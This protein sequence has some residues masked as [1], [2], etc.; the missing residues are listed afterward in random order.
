MCVSLLNFTLKKKNKRYFS[1][2][3]LIVISQ[4]PIKYVFLT[5]LHL[6]QLK[7]GRTEALFYRHSDSNGFE[8]MTKCYCCCYQIKG[9]GILEILK[10]RKFL[11]MN[12]W[13][14]R[15]KNKILGIENIK[16]HKNI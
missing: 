16:I 5:L 15:G 11:E 2:H 10:G 3:R 13:K 7:R 1:A 8:D 12:Y 9:E 6:S 14:S 4:S